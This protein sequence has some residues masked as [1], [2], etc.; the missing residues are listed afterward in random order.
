[1]RVLVISDTHIPNRAD[2]IPEKIDKFIS[3]QNFDVVICLGDLTGES[4]FEY[5]KS[6]AK[7]S[8]FVRGNMDYLNLPRSLKIQVEKVK[9]GAIHGDGIF[10]R[11]NRK[12]LLQI[13]KKFEVNVLLSGHTHTPDV[14]EQDYILLANPG[15]ATGVWGGGGNPT[16]PS[17]ITLDIAENTVE[18]KLYELEKEL[19]CTYSGNYKF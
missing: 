3:E 5:I 16:R 4:I 13:A 14:F 17:I 7:K 12:Q 9:I 15:S 10:P 1:M 11:G 18:L 2:W 6:L 8:Y 19:V